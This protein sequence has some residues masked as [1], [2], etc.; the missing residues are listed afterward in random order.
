MLDCLVIGGVSPIGTALSAALRREGMRVATTSRRS[1][2][3][4]AD[5]YLDLETLSGLDALPPAAATAIVAAETR[6]SVCDA[7]PSRTGRI[8]RDAPVEIARRRLAD[9][10]RVLF[11]SS[12]AVFDGGVDRIAETARPKPNS[13][14]GRQKAEA[15]RE[16]FKLSGTSAVLRPAKVV[17]PDFPLF[18]QWCGALGRGEPIDPFHDMFFAPVFVDVVAE[19]AAS[20]MRAPEARGAFHVSASETISYADAALRIAARLGAEPGLVRPVSARDRLDPRTAWLPD[21][22][23]LDCSRLTR[24]TGFTPPPPLDAVDAFLTAWQ[25]N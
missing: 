13:V 12:I 21:Y 18:A 23:R 4:G 14:Y 19:A 3:A 10:G 7:E 1:G 20:L 2:A 15:E 5:H 17:H 22:A 9:G 11:F 6:F 24:R 25:G 8:N 16:I